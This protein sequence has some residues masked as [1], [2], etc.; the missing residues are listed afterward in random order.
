MI[1]AIVQPTAPGFGRIVAIGNH[2]EMVVTALPGERIVVLPES[3]LR[4]R[5]CPCIP[6]ATIPYRVRYSKQG[7][8]VSDL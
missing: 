5:P 3:T 8:Y 7:G 6:G 4:I 1:S 2:G